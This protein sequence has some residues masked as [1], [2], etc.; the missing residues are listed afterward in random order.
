LAAVFLV[1]LLLT[2]WAGPY[3]VVRHPHYAAVE[4]DGGVCDA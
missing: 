2:G 3:R 1:A 4:E